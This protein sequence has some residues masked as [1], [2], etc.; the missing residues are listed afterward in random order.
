MCTCLAKTMCRN[1]S[2]APSHPILIL[3][4]QGFILNISHCLGYGQ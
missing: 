3:V 2:A 1:I 4:T